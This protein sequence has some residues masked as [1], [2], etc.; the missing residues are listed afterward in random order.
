M[1]FTPAPDEL[2]AYIRSAPG[3]TRL[4]KTGEGEFGGARETRYRFTSQTWQGARWEH[5][6]AIYRPERADATGTAIFV[7]TGDGPFERDRR[8]IA[9]VLA[10]AKMPVVVLYD[11]PNQPIFEMRE[12]DL[13]AHTFERYLETADPTWPLL[14]PMTAAATRAMDAVKRETAGDPDPVRRFVA[15]GG[16]KRGWTTWLTAAVGRDDLAGIA[17]MVFDNLDFTAQMRH[18]MRSWGKYSPMIED[19]TRRGLQQKLD[20]PEGR[21]LE[22]LVDPYAYRANIQAPTLIVNGANDPYWSADAL[23]LYWGRLRQPRWA[24]IV[25]NAGHD[26]GD[27]QWALAT[28]SAFARCAAGLGDMPKAAFRVTDGWAAI[29]AEPGLRSLALWIAESPDLDFRE[30]AWR[31]AGATSV[32]ADGMMRVAAPPLARGRKR[33]LLA[34]AEVDVAGVRCHLSAPV[35]VVP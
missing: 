32:V 19:Y 5:D 30:A 16:S 31:Q 11:V 3:P 28:V 24:V 2:E 27:G 22:S 34:V 7:I 23:S 10:T 12:D 25:P 15:T 9:A 29:A 21:K 26:L 18:Q 14:M 6:L 33:A 35:R 1:T 13:I 20:S 17:P 4:K 8:M